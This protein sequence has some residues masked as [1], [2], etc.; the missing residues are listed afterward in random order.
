MTFF[1]G[2][3]LQERARLIIHAS[4]MGLMLESSVPE[5]DEPAYREESDRW[6]FLALVTS[7]NYRRSSSALWSAACDAYVDPELGWLFD[8]RSV[9]ESEPPRLRDALVSSR[10]AIQPIRQVQNWQ[11]ISRGVL[12]GWG[13]FRGLVEECGSVAELRQVVCSSHKSSFPY[14]SG[15]K[16]FNYWCFLLA[17]KGLAQ[18]PDDELIDIA[19]D[20]HVAKASREIGLVPAGD[21]SSAVAIAAKWRT[22][23]AG[24]AIRPSD[25]TVPLWLWSRSGFSPSI[26]ELLQHEDGWAG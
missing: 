13:S 22:A 21:T 1:G 7:V 6:N 10:V 19:V 18:F 15:P 12:E 23:L 8:L 11:V 26:P 9:C 3:S 5:D 25:L 4:R 17:R 24:S 2:A 20:S 14:L 16:L